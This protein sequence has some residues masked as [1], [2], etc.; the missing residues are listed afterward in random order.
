MYIVRFRNT[1]NGP[2]SKK[3]LRGYALQVGIGLDFN[4]AT[5]GR[6]KHQAASRISGKTLAWLTAEQREWDR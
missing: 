3:F 1:H 6:S 5:P 4:W 2:R